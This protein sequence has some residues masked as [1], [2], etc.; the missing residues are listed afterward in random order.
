MKSL[1][2][3][4]I[5]V[6]VLALVVLL[7]AIA[8]W[9]LASFDADKY[10]GVAIDWMKR[11][12]DRT[13]VVGGP[14]KLSVFPRIGV[15]VSKLSLSERGRSDPFAALDEASLAV[16][17][18]PL[19]RNQLVVDRISARGLRVAY[20]RT[21]KGERN[22]D[23]L[24]KRDDKAPAGAGPSLKFDVGRID[25]EDLHATL[26]DEQ[27][28]LHGDVTLVS[29]TTGR[30]APGV[31]SPV[32]LKA[33]LAL[34]EPAIKGT[35]SGKTRLAW[36]AE[37]ATVALSDMK[38]GFKGDVPAASAVDAS[39]RGALTWDGGKS[40]LHAR[41]VELDLAATLG[42][43][44]LAGSSASLDSFGYDPT[45]K[46]IALGKLQLKLAGL[47][48]KSPF[49][50]ALAW[51]SLEVAGETLKGSALSGTVSLA[52]ETSMD[53]RFQSGPPSGNFDQVRLPAFT[54]ALKGK[55][56]PRQIDGTLK[57]ALSL[58]V[59]TRSIA[60]EQLDL[61]AKIDEPS[62]QPVA[63]AVRGSASA[64]PQGAAWNLA[65]QLSANSFASDGNASFG[66]GAP[67]VQMQARF[68]SLDLNKLLAPPKAGTVAAPAGTSADTALDLAGLR[69]VNGKFTL[70]A[71]RF[72]FRQYRVADA[73][74]DASLDNGALQLS[75]LQGQ[76]WGG[77][78]EATGFAD[79]RSN[80][81]GV[82]LNASGVNVN[83]LLK[84]VAQS[85]RLEGT[86]RVTADVQSAGKTTGEMRSR[87][88]GNTALQLRDGA[89]KGI[90]LAK[91]F[92]QA[93]ATLGMKQ[94]EVQ[95]A[96]QTEKTDFSELNA[97]FQIADGIARNNDLDAKSPFLRLG[98]GGTI[99]VGK[100][101]IDYVARAT[102]TE[103]T[104]G[105]GGAELA[106]LKGVTVPVR[107]SG[108][109]EAMDWNIQWSAV[110]AGAAQAKL[111]EKVR[112]KLGKELG[113]KPTPEAASAPAAPRDQLKERLRGLL[114]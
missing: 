80:R 19:L 107:L 17:L 48:G 53:G 93:K 74:I 50:L 92:R 114:K 98:G 24:L 20:T 5:A 42:A 58:R 13:L 23:D 88:K 15:K 22:F 43:M 7:A 84:D 6:A 18:L 82:K 32:E 64:S 83:A 111:E 40:A 38:L 11:E 87:L 75:R 72:V 57:S 52:G 78:V 113:L 56:G 69:A 36:N 90:N 86:G 51:P 101:R 46:A 4:R 91:S 29:L 104:K 2:I 44:K 65:G 26:R 100:G 96:Q 70:R 35:L 85:D 67:N 77:N 76:A 25:L 55:S 10:K 108:P 60:F 95:K 59:P 89:I 66:G 39:I 8:A 81:V 12:H 99:D 97:T 54:L 28:K 61:Q 112:D 94:D 103:T 49:T 110:A 45:R 73:R 109:L 31:E 16:E 68:D 9:L 14:L 62:L 27:G 63:L 71:G 106:A 37:S 3:R 1:W 41:G 21:A 105:Q 102:V 47:Q 33:E 79:A 34:K 30:I